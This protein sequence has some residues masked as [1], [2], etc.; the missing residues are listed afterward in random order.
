M[1]G[2]TEMPHMVENLG[3]K[4]VRSTPLEIG[5]LAEGLPAVEIQS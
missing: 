4:R 5:D 2:T 1:L 3:A